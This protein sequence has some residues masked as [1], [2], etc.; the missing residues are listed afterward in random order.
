[1]KGELIYFLEHL[2][3][4]FDDSYEIVFLEYNEE[5]FGN[6]LCCLKSDFSNVKIVRDRG[7]LSGSVLL[8][9]KIYSLEDVVKNVADQAGIGEEASCYIL[10]ERLLLKEE[11]LISGYIKS[12]TI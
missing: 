7:E 4:E 5:V 9:D 12:L 3:N 11:S 6:I 10:F 2:K 1:M 8:E